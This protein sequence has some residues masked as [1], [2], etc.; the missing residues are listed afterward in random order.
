MVTP[1]Q[2]TNV[3]R[4]HQSASRRQGVGREVF[5]G[6]PG[7]GISFAPRG[8]SAHQVVVEA[9]GAHGQGK[10]GPKPKAG[11]GPRPSCLGQ[12]GR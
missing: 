3:K 5:E 11:A 7:A 9:R 12:H 2:A 8:P 1:T 4:S 6:D 10:P